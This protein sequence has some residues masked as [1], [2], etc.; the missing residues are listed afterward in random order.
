[1]AGEKLV[2]IIR[3]GAKN[4]IPQT[5]LTDLLFGIVTSVSPL[6]ILIENRFEVD[7]SF[8]LLSPFCYENKV[9]FE[10]PEHDHNVTIENHKGL[11]HK[12]YIDKTKT[13]ETEESE[14]I[15]LN[16]SASSTKSAKKTIEVILWNGLEIG[17]K[18]SLLRVS[19]GQKYYV[20]DKGGN[21]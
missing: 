10:I 14:E 1:M 21:K 12:H 5:T 19:N 8:L 20:L 7:S 2:G 9:K 13:T 15:I 4:A 6:K 16:H 17:D 11:K 18:V 3:Q